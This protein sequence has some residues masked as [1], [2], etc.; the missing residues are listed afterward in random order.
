[1]PYLTPLSHVAKKFL[2]SQLQ[3]Q[4]KPPSGEQHEVLDLR[5]V[6]EVH[7]ELRAVIL[8]Q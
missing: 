2:G 1:M 7:Y 4:L 3:L 8:L 5:E 6:C